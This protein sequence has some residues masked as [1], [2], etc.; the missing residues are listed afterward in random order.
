MLKF[1]PTR[2][3][4]CEQSHRRRFL[5]DVGSL[6]M[7]GL[8]L[9]LLLRTRAASAENSTTS[10]V[11]N[12]ILIWTQ[13][14]TSHHDTLDPKPESRAEVRGEFG[15]IDTTIP[16][17]QFSDQMPNFSRELNNFSVMRNLNPQNGSHGTADAIMMSGQRINPSLTYPCFGSVIAK[18]RG[19]GDSMPPFVQIGTHLDRRWGGST[20]GYLGINYNPFELPGD[21]NESDFT[22]RDLTPPSGIS[23][24]RSDKRRNALKRLDTFQRELDK[25]SEAFQAL[26]EYYQNAFSI[27]TSPATQ[28]AFRLEQ[29]D[30][31]VRDQYGRSYLG[32]SC[33]LARR[34]IEA[35]AQF[36]T[37]T[38]GDWDTH[39]DNF[40]RLRKLLP[41]IDIAFP[42]LIHDLKQRGMLDQTLVVWLTDFGRTPIINSAAGRDHW[43]S[44]GN[45]CMAG[46]GVPSGQVFGKT[47]ATGG[48]TVG[49]EHYPADIAATIY[50][51]LGIP[52]TMTH[53]TPDGRPIRLCEGL[54]IDELTG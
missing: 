18:Q 38:S 45:V 19:F 9:D 35:G 34:L 28:N 25:P 5:M 42:A 7:M 53:T 16:G 21:P 30:N 47:D 4:D 27:V 6:S 41:P 10:K 3:S 2:L 8:S 24:S 46:A 14:G 43:S 36:V 31:K 49:G 11:V 17:I 32:Q 33:L 1:Y 26:D 40:N 29:E 22:V 39:N 54:P 44:V 20:A 12:C 48:Q 23:L 51:K 13:G 37:V 15:V 50:S 52:L